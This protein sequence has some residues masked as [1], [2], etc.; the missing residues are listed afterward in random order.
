[1][2]L[3]LTAK[4]TA[5]YKGITVFFYDNGTTDFKA[6]GDITDEELDTAIAAEGGSIAGFTS[7]ILEH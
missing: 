1:M 3:I 4:Y 6:Y 7:T 2:N 5:A